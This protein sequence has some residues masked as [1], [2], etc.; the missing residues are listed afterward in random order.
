MIE[1]IKVIRSLSV[2]SCATLLTLL[3]S[4]A[5]LP[6]TIT[7]VFVSEASAQGIY[8]VELS[9]DDQFCKSKLF[10]S[11]SKESC[12]AACPGGA[13]ECAL[14]Q[15]YKAEF[16]QELDEDLECFACT[17]SISCYDLGLMYELWDCMVCEAD[18]K[19]ECV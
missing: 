15:T 6:E 2:F 18:P 8:S 11:L 13:V 12:A 19:K 10:G 5:F 1:K 4:P 7:N 16:N 3:F 14:V 17:S 9:E